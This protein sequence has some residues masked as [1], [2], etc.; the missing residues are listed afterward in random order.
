MFYYQF[1]ENAI[2]RLLSACRRLEG[3]M[4][5]QIEDEENKDDSKV[6]CS[7]IRLIVETC[8][9]SSNQLLRSSSETVLDGSR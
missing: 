4:T 7:E 9:S 6:L 3:Y 5:G 8:V 2:R 1:A